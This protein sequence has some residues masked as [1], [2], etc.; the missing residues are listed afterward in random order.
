MRTP[1]PFVRSLLAAAAL[2]ALAPQAHAVVY[3]WDIGYLSA[4]GLPASM[5]AADTLNIG[6]GNYKY[7]DSTLA[8]AGTVNW[9][10]TLYFQYGYGINNSGTWNA[11][12]DASLLNSYAGG[13]FNNSGIFRKSG[14]SGSTAIGSSITFT[15][16]GTLDAQVGTIDFNGGAATFNAGTQFIGA[17]INQVSSNASFVGAF[18]SQNLLL[19]GGIHTGTGAVVS[20][21]STVNW[22]V[23]YLAG[24]WTVAAGATLKLQAGNYKYTYA[25]V[26]NQG[27]MAA[28]DTLYF[29]YGG[30][31]TNQ[32]VYDFRGDVGL[33]NS[34]AGGV[35]TNSGTLR[36]SVGAGSSSVGSSIAFSNTGVIEAQVGTISFDGGSATFYGGTQFTGAGQVAVTGN[37]SFFGGYTTNSNLTLGN[38]ATFTGGDGSAGSKAVVN[39]NTTWVTG[40]LAGNWE[41]SAGRTLT[42]ASGNYK[43]TQGSVVNKG[44]IAAQDTLYMQYGSTLAN[45]AV[46]DLQGDVGVQNGYAGGNFINSGTLRKSAGAGSSSI[47]SSIAFSNTGVIEAQTGTINFDGGSASFLNG[48]QFNGAGQVAVTNHASFIGGYTTNSNLTLGN[49]AIFTGGD[50]SAGSKAVVNGNTT[51]ATGYLAGNWE[52]SAGR[53]LTLALGNYKNTQGSLVNKGSIAAQDT[54]YMQY[55]STL[56]NM[57]VYDLQGDVG[58]QN[59]YAGGNF[60]NSGTL[61]KSTGAGSSSIGSS[62]AFSNTGV[63]EARTGTITFDGG[64]ATFYAGTQFA[65][66]G[67]VAVTNHATFIGA[68]TTSGNLTLS[69]G[70]LTGGDGSAGSKA[71]INGD[72]RWTSGTMV[73]AWEVATGRTLAVVPGSGTALIGSLVNQGAVLATDGLGFQYGGTLNNTGTYTLQGDVGLY[74]SYAGG[75]F[76]NTGLLVKSAGTGTSNVSSIAFSN[77]VGGVVD[78]QTG[79]I[80][81]PNDFVNQ[82]TLKGL[83]AY[84]TNTLTNAG[85]VAPGASP[86][87]LTVTANFVQLAG[88]VLDTELQDLAHTDLLAINGNAVLG[89]TLALACYSNCTF[90]IGDQIVVLDATGTLSGSFAALTLTGFAT[91]AFNVTGLGRAAEVLAHLGP[92]GCDL[93]VQAVHLPPQVAQNFALDAPLFGFDPGGGNG[94]RGQRQHAVAQQHD[95]DREDA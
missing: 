51:W 92:H 35:F 17:G 8:T 5:L 84:A 80:Q 86:G 37:A 58:V 26:L 2:A 3:T 28:Y 13:A 62:I 66:A 59:G 46:Y 89:G 68:Y 21:G 30:P 4:Q 48:T 7:V 24:D 29:Q 85:H 44:N 43:N 49:N 34:Y 15:N 83:G 12:A 71:V 18:S 91:G 90:A 31:I 39:G 20:T 40:Y 6:A 81:L 61:R 52:V 87:T 16:S 77:A 63:I 75:N 25:S 70:T 74:N 55:G 79:T 33:A 38:N 78:V 11:T 67:Q 27:T 88:G 65:G 72:T 47:G 54:L 60:V 69:G 22:A 23:G 1:Q 76:V 82:G 19:A 93:G 95:E 50:G 73:G 14:G 64:S 36:K 41:V 45:M 56:T 42:L 10:D 53:T 9:L 94:R 32:G 57:A